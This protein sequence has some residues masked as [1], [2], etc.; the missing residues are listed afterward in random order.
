MNKIIDQL[1]LVAGQWQQ[2]GDKKYE[3]EFSYWLNELRWA[4][5]TSPEGALEIL[6]AELA[7]L[8]EKEEMTA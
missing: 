8:G 1:I 6:L 7:E 2:F 3:R 4:A 5:N